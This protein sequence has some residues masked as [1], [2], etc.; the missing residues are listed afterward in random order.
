M[1]EQVRERERETKG[2]GIHNN[3]TGKNVEKD[4]QYNK[5]AGQ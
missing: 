3:I 1:G 5:T 4:E 2:K